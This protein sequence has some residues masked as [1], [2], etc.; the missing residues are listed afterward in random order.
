MAHRDRDGARAVNESVVDQH[1]QD[2]PYHLWRAPCER[3]VGVDVDDE[4][5]ARGGDTGPECV[6]K[7]LAKQHQVRG[8]TY[9]R[10]IASDGEQ[11]LDRRLEAVDLADRAVQHGSRVMLGMKRKIAETRN[12]DL[13]EADSIALIEAYQTVLTQAQ[14]K[15]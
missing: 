6:V 2:L 3:H 14:T 5:P 9:Q 11:R 4:R 7:V 8:A 10:G 1:R 13:D 12:A 15:A